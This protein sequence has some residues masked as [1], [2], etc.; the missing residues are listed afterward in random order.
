MRSRRERA[1]P[2]G[3][4]PGR[5]SRRWLDPGNAAGCSRGL[6]LD[7]FALAAEDGQA[8]LIGHLLGAGRRIVILDGPPPLAC[9]VRGRPMVE[10]AVKEK[11]ATGLEWR[12]HHL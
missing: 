8:L 5:P 7:V 3:R 12:G 11:Q 2:V 10:Q 1:W 4:W 9:R 6:A